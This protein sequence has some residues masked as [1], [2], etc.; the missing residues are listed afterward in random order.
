MRGNEIVVWFKEMKADCVYVDEMDGIS[1][2][3]FPVC[4]SLVYV[5][6]NMQQKLKHKTS[7]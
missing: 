5:H 7:L 6:N 3:G 1:L 2:P 4:C